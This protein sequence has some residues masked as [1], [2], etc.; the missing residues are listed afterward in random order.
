MSNLITISE[1]PFLALHEN[2][3]EW[4]K[5]VSINVAVAQVKLPPQASEKDRPFY[6]ISSSPRE[7]GPNT[8]IPNLVSL[9]Q[10]YFL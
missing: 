5:T 4:L 2:A 1:L 3:L 7:S 8:G 10:P 9:D 6:H